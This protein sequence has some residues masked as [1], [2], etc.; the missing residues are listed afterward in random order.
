[1]P[2]TRQRILRT[3]EFP[4]L[5]IHFT[6]ELRTCNSFDKKLGKFFRY[7]HSPI[8]LE[9]LFCLVRNHLRPFLPI[10]EDWELRQF[11]VHRGPVRQ[12]DGGA[13]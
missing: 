2:Q 11:V 13:G 3:P 6:K 7:F 12:P 8:P 9:G 10:T 4:L 5:L 1:M